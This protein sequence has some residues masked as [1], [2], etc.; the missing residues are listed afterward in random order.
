VVARPD[1]A[2]VVKSQGGERV[3]RGGSGAD[4]LQLGEGKLVHLALGR[5]ADDPRNPFRCG[6]RPRPEKQRLHAA[7]HRGVDAD[8]QRQG[9][10]RHDR[11]AGT[12]E[13]RADGEFH[14]RGWP[15]NNFTAGRWRRSGGDE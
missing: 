1:S 15:E 11:V 3:E 6:K 14:G 13:Q 4:L 10:K 8:A 7:D 9:E 5:E 12:A 2:K